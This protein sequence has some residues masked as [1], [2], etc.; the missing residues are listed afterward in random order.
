MNDL[1]KE[2]IVTAQ[3]SDH[4]HVVCLIGVI[5]AGTP[6]MLLVSYCEVR[7]SCLASCTL[8]AHIRP[9]DKILLCYAFCS[10]AMP[11]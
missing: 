3:L 8:L 2:A 11:G 1:Y 5:T 9:A 6:A 4:K 10:F 7:F